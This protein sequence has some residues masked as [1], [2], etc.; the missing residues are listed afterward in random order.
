MTT[1][2]FPSL[3]A[4]GS[5]AVVAIAGCGSSSKDDA[6]PKAATG[7]SKPAAA[8][9]AGDAVAIKDF[10]F[11]P[12]SIAVKAGTKLTFTN[13]DSAA[14]TA[15]STDSGVFDTDK[16]EQGQKKIVTLSKPGTYAYVCAFH[17]FMKGTVTVE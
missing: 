4:A 1:T 13:E 7:A 17:P 9:P 2:R 15:T 12:P 5:L 11:G 14:H 8:G 3:L 10:K 6:S 16:L